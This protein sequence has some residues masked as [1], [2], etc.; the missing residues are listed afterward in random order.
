[1]W[2]FFFLFFFIVLSCSSQRQVPS[3]EPMSKSVKTKEV[4]Q[5]IKHVPPKEDISSS[6]KEPKSDF[7]EKSLTIETQKEVISPSPKQPEKTE[8]ETREASFEE[9]SEEDQ[10]IAA[11]MDM[12]A[13]QLHKAFKDGKILIAQRKA[14]IQIHLVKNEKNLVQIIL[15]EM[16]F[17]VTNDS[18]REPIDLGKKME[19]SKKIG[20]KIKRYLLS[21]KVTLLE[22][23]RHFW[24]DEKGNIDFAEPDKTFRIFD[25]PLQADL[26]LIPLEPRS[27]RRG[28]IDICKERTLVYVYPVIEK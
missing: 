13:V 14:P 19:I 7:G 20:K 3:V 4:V 5:P 18:G 1:M 12:A 22:K 6:S 24:Y 15:S 11:A 27:Q 17:K 10:E 21:D 26:V 16:V 2:H 9:D 23:E 8:K 25:R 28:Y